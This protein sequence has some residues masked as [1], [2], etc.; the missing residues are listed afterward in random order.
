M[1]TKALTYRS[2]KIFILISTFLLILSSCDIV[3][4]I[5]DV[6]KG[7]DDDI[8]DAL[9]NSTTVGTDGG[10]INADELTLTIP[11]GAFSQAVDINIYA[12][13]VTDGSIDDI[14]TK[15]YKIEGLPDQYF[16]P[17]D[18]R[19]KHNGTINE[20]TYLIL[21][22]E[23][24]IPSLDS[25]SAS[26][27]YFDAV[28]VGD[29]IKSQLPAMTAD[30]AKVA[31][32]VDTWNKEQKLM[33]LSNR[34]THTT[35]N[36]HF[37]INYNSSLDNEP[38][39][40]DL[41]KYLE[42]AYSKLQNIGF[43]YTD[44]TN[45]PINVIIETFV[46]D[47]IGAN[48]LHC[49]TLVGTNYYYLKFNRLSLNDERAIKTASIHEFFHI[50]QYFYDNRNFAS[51]AKSKPAHHWFNEACSVYSEEL[52]MGPDYVSDIRTAHGMQPFYGLQA[53]S[54]GNAQNHGYGMS[55]Y[56]HYLVKQYGQSIL[57]DIYKSIEAGKHVVNAIDLSLNG[58]LF[59]D[60]NEFLKQYAQGAVYSDFGSTNLISIADG[61][62]DINSNTDILKTFTANYKE[63]SGKFYIVQLG[64]PNF[65][66]DTSLEISIDQ[67]LCDITVFQFPTVGTDNVLAQGLKSCVVSDLKGLKQ[68]NKRLLVMVTNSYC[69]KIPTYS[70][71]NMDIN[72]K[73]EVKEEVEVLEISNVYLS[74]TLPYVKGKTRTLGSSAAWAEWH[75]EDQNWTLHFKVEHEAHNVGYSGSFSNNVYTGTYTDYDIEVFR[76]TTWSSYY[77]IRTINGTVQLTFADTPYLNSINNLHVDITVTGNGIWD[78]GF[79]GQ[80]YGS[81]YSGETIAT[82]HIIIDYNGLLI[83]PL[84]S[85][86]D[87]RID[88]ELYDRT[89]TDIQIFY[90]TNWVRANGETVDAEYISHI[91][92]GNPNTIFVHLYH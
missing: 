16:K 86:S 31:S 26:N 20:Q 46:G 69:I 43:D 6:F 44:R 61:T 71:T 81:G 29:S 48:G 83:G 3:D 51:K 12:S 76:L 19:I 42:G 53:G 82:E 79:W 37:I 58:N 55:A 73:M 30:L 62:F 14:A 11:A 5:A 92:G 85:L 64:N 56:V 89:D 22:E 65:K 38:N 75:G 54:V 10:I 57:V 32:V 40:I 39:I 72:V 49:T 87:N 7:E 90:T 68:Q 88:Y 78:N 2:V 9:I 60:Y 21:Q 84:S 41:G 13:S 23:T 52:V 25:I 4:A 50:V 34:K 70:P 63:F 18:V 24:Y 1:T 91:F 45:W 33:A 8:T 66:D 36:N 47:D 35:S 80:M 67:D 74:V 77:V 28:V 17:I 59:L 27:I 15:V